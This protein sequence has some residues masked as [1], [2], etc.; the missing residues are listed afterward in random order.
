MAQQLRAYEKIGLAVVIG[1]LVVIILAAFGRLESGTFNPPY[2]VLILN[3]VFIAISD[4]IV[5]AISARSFLRYGQ[6]G[7][8]LLTGA[9]VIDGTTS[10][11]AGWAAGISANANF[12]IFNVGMLLASMVQIFAVI[13]LSASLTARLPSKRK[14]L[15]T[16]VLFASVFSIVALTILTLL[17]Y[18][19]AFFFQE[20][21]SPLGRFVLGLAVFFNAL[22]SLII[23][24]QFIKSKARAL[25]WY[26]LALAISAIG[27]VGFYIVPDPGGV[28]QWL[29]RLALYVGSFY[30][31]LV[32]LSLTSRTRGASEVTERWYETFGNSSEQL[33]ALSGNMLD[34]FTYIR[35]VTGDDG[36]AIDGVFLAVNSAFESS[37]GL[38]KGEV[39]G[40]AITETRWGHDR[41][42][43][44][45][46]E[47][48]GQVASTGKSIKFE[49]RIAELQKWLRLSAYSPEKGYVIMLIDDI[50][51]AKESE[52]E[53]E[54]Y[55]KNLEAMVEEKTKQL[56]DAE[57]LATIG[58]V[59]G[60]VGHDIRN[61]LQAINSEV[62]L[63]RSELEEKA[64]E[65]SKDK[66]IQESLQSID[67]QTAYI[68]KIVSDLQ[69]LSKPLKPELVEIDLC[70]AI[71]EAVSTVKVPPSIEK[72]VVCPQSPL[73]VKSDPSFLKRIMINLVTNAIQAMPKGGKLTVSMLTET[74][75]VFVSVEDTGVGISEESR[76]K[77]FTPL[78]TTKAKGQGFGLVIIKRMT[79]ALG[80]SVSVESEVGKGTKFTISLPLNN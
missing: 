47:T 68:Q 33:A 37:T 26:S 57:R 74:N 4:I 45:L 31:I 24:Y 70:T 12:T 63:A 71:P 39:L 5:A 61:P 40:K 66:N 64:P 13:Y 17:G 77:L 22:A 43:R 8:L 65:G 14:I 16:I 62:Y 1:F 76:K 18:T 52:R 27:L 80:G 75:H 41:A 23:G 79:E 10:V 11:F 25:Y 78:F 30:F 67:E 42:A 3:I 53:L 28:S 20:A 29:G 21:L 51:D 69:D 38:K 36:K 34:G 54:E 56:R 7:F 2:L 55:S 50:T 72:T 48:L 32:V 49:T 6:I 15:L 19:A 44:D 59:A 73:K 60:M 58:Q 35:I 46:I 9:L